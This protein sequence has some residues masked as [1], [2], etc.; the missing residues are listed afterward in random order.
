M[1]SMN[2]DSSRYSWFW[3]NYDTCMKWQEQH[4]VAYWKSKALALEYERDALLQYVL[5]FETANNDVHR[6]MRRGN[7]SFQE[8]NVKP[9][10]HRSRKRGMYQR[11]KRRKRFRSH[12]R[13]ENSPQSYKHDESHE[14]NEDSVNK[15]PENE[16]NDDINVDDE[17]IEFFKQSLR[18]KMELREKRKASEESDS[19]DSSSIKKPDAVR[20]EEMRMLYGKNHAMIQGMETAMQLTFERNCDILNPVLWP[21]L[22]LKM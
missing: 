10:G 12:A 3:R 14:A 17:L 2:V 8:V 11:D 1:Q 16:S 19:N 20:S 9:G 21:V 5:G 15:D 22:P 18:H 13:N 7:S 6:P 4:K